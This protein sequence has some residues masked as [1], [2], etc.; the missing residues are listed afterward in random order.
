MWPTTGVG[1]QVMLQQ[2]MLGLGEQGHDVMPCGPAGKA[3]A[4]Y[5]II[6]FGPAGT[7][8]GVEQVR[9]QQVTLGLGVQTVPCGPATNAGLVE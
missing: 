9:F 7:T 8:G 5:Q 6:M 3:G 1:E 4:G 2:V